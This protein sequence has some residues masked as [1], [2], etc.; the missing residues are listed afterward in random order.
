MH[1]ALKVTKVK[2]SRSKTIR[3]NKTSR[4]KN[5]KNLKNSFFDLEVLFGQNQSIASSSTLIV[6]YIYI[7]GASSGLRA[8]HYALRRDFR[9]EG[10]AKPSPRGGVW[11]GVWGGACGWVQC[12]ISFDLHILGQKN[13][14]F[15]Q[16][17]WRLLKWKSLGQRQ[18]GKIRL[19]GPKILK[20]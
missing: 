11:V 14:F 5:L 3:K 6:M 10:R 1:P 12:T 20:I 4:S 2:K 17:H 8:G 15:G 7:W 18:S 19:L 13:T 9:P 16:M